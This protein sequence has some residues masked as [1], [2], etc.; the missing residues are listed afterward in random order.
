MKNPNARLTPKQIE[1]IRKD[2][3]KR[4]YTARLSKRF[5]VSAGH[6]CNIRK[7]KVWK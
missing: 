6:I 4:G 2:P 5:G 7:G 1:V 3:G